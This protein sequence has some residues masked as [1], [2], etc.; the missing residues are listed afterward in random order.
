MAHLKLRVKPPF[1]QN[2]TAVHPLDLNSKSDE[3][4]N[5]Q[6]SLMSNNAAYPISHSRKGHNKV[7]NMINKGNI[8]TYIL[9]YTHKHPPSPHKHTHWHKHIYTHTFT[10]TQIEVVGERRNIVRDFVSRKKA[11]IQWIIFICVTWFEF[12]WSWIH[13]IYFVLV[14]CFFISGVCGIAVFWSV[15][16]ELTL[17]LLSMYL[18]FVSISGTAALGVVVT[19]FPTTLRFEQRFTFN[20]K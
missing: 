4:A 16:A 6:Q 19:I 3:A 12:I 2:S 5:R 18:A 20:L 17:A 1:S 7:K 9:S 11:T 10:Q 13:V 8:H 14:S 15:N